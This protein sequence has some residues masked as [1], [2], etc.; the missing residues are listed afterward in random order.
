MN[1]SVRPGAVVLVDANVVIEAHRAGA[2]AALAGAYDMATVEEGV[3]ETSMV[4]KR[5]SPTASARPWR[6][7]SAAAPK[8]A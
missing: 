8:W 5:D 1:D 3:T 4:R 6:A 2:W 7:L